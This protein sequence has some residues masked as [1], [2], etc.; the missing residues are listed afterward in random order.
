MDSKDY[1]GLLP[2]NLYQEMSVKD[3]T[4][5]V[6]QGTFCCS[7]DRLMDAYACT[8]LDGR[9]LQ[10][11]DLFCQM[12]GYE[13]DDLLSM[14]I[15]DITPC[16]WHAVENEIL[17]TELKVR[18]YTDIYQKEYIRKDGSIIPVELRLCLLHDD[19][20]TPVGIWALVRDISERRET[21]KILLRSQEEFKTLAENSPDIIIRFDRNCRH[22]FLNSAAAAAAGLPVDRLMG[23]KIAEI[24]LP[25]ETTAEWERRIF[26]VIETGEILTIDDSM[27]AETGVRHFQYR[28]APEKALDGTI[29]SALVV[30]SEITAKKQAEDALRREKTLLEIAQKLAHLGTWTR[31]MVTEEVQWSEETFRIFGLAHD[32]K[33]S[34]DDFARRIHP[35]D[36]ARVRQEM[37]EALKGT[38]PV[39]VDYRII[40]PDGQTRHLTERCNFVSNAQGKLIRLEG[41]VQDVT[42]LKLAQQALV[43]ANRDLEARVV[44]RTRE[45]RE[46]DHFLIQQSRMAAMGEMLANIAHQ[47][48]QPL[49]NIGLLLQRLLLVYDMADFNRDFLVKSV[50]TA[51][52]LVKHM[53]QTIDDFRNF[54]NPDKEKVLFFVDQAIKNTINLVQDGIGDSGIYLETDLQ[55]SGQVLGCPNEFCQA[56]LNII[57][58]ARDALMEQK[59]TGGRI[60]ITSVAKGESHLITIGDNAGGIPD[61]ILG[62]IFDPYFST[63]GKQGSG[64]GLYM[65]KTIIEQSM[66]GEVTVTNKSSGAEFQIAL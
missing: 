43:E 58:N 11:N 1:I 53:S 19:S 23:K 27:P 37:V 32:Q 10:C 34:F 59:I 6:S 42:P 5:S 30:G 65:T 25:M 16:H 12:T 36:A 15:R 18:S 57:M 8:D 52:H 63:K 51:D 54:F 22:V 56:L 62:H 7:Y 9:L 20:G 38:G 14:N 3:F 31:D 61:E 28:I 64:I 60:T 24:G 21:R 55:N 33:I 44:Q 48:R 66:G 41:C 26:S 35:D 17:E 47:W 39:N 4:R 13:R 45:L 46:K 40:R 29:I 2:G 49:N 50:G